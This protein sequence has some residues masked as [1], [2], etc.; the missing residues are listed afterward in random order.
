MKE[1]R[2][3]TQPGVSFLGAKS[4]WRLI[5]NF[6]GREGIKD[7]IFLKESKPKLEFPEGRRRRG[8]GGGGG[9]SMD[10]FWNNAIGNMHV[11]VTA[12]IF[13]SNFF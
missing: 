2:S 6:E 12:F 8:E 13:G 3:I 10:I 4:R 7:R 1:T 5:G 9:G 11:Y